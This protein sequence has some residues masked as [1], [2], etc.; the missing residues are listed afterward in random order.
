MGEEK[1]ENHINNYMYLHTR[2][3]EESK[4]VKKEKT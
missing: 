3:I 2:K 4:K 1:E